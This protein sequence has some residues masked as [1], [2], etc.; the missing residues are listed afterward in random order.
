MRLL[1]QSRMQFFLLVKHKIVKYSF[2]T[3]A[4]SY[5]KKRER[6][7]ERD[8]ER[9]R[10]LFYFYIILVGYFVLL[11]EWYTYIIN[12]LPI[13]FKGV[14]DTEPGLFISYT[15]VMLLSCSHHA[16]FM[17]LWIRPHQE[18]YSSYFFST[19]FNSMKYLLIFLNILYPNMVK[20][21]LFWGH[22]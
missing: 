4:K 6:E 19:T 9:E 14:F 17:L 21:F 16:A 1:W 22:Y 15:L 11:S 8:R 5:K 13:V 3:I 20:H 10:C 12:S 2:F 7:G 18:Q